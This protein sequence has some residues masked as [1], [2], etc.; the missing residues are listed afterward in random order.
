MTA[1][2]DRQLTC[3]ACGDRV[4][5]TCNINIAIN[6][7][8]SSKHELRVFFGKIQLSHWKVGE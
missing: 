3:A 5:Y 6:G 8:Q 4:L 7:T 1:L 2:G